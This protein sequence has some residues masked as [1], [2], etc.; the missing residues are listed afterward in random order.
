MIMCGRYVLSDTEAI[1]KKFRIEIKASHNIAPSQDVLVLKPIPEMM[2]WSYSP[3]W[4]E[5]MNLINCR[6]ETLLEKPSFK[7]V[8]YTHLRAHET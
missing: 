4:K 5:D 1:K 7:A 2:K 6:H 8:S 3:K